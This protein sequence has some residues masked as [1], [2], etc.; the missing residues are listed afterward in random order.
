MAVQ[1]TELFRSLKN[2]AKLTCDLMADSL[3]N[4]MNPPL[5]SRMRIRPIAGSY[6]FGRVLKPDYESFANSHMSVILES[7]QAKE[8]LRLLVAD[9]QI[10]SHLERKVGSFTSTNR[11]AKEA[12]LRK[13]LVSFIGQQ[14][15]VRFNE[16][17]FIQTYNAMEDFFYGGTVQIE[18]SIPLENFHSDVDEIDLGNGWKIA[19][20]SRE[21]LEEVLTF[22]DYPETSLMSL[23]HAL[24]WTVNAPKVI[25]EQGEEY[26]APQEYQQVH[27]IVREMLTAIRLFKSG[28]VGRRMTQ[29]RRKSWSFGG[30]SRSMGYGKPFWKRPYRIEPHEVESLRE[31]VSFYRSSSKDRN[32]SVAVRRVNY[33]VER[34]RTEDTLVDYLIAFESLFLDNRR[35]LSYRLSLRVSTNLRHEKKSRTEVFDDMRL[36]YKIRS[37]I[38]HGEEKKKIHKE[39]KKK[40]YNLRDFTDKISSYLLESIKL[41]LNHLQNGL[42]RKEIVRILDSNVLS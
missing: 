21:R 17:A 32:S 28:D 11:V 25:I 9:E 12:V 19:K 23:S 27:S 20:M 5:K 39:L 4:G 26:D 8:C 31:F 40:G 36:A 33:A 22:R 29:I 37:M 3:K 42:T 15:D 24:I 7:P 38:V 34:E 13:F 18:V 1:N 6:A 30:E 14:S 41:Y 2:L 10:N 16:S 35:E